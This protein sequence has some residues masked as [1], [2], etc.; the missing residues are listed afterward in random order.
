MLQLADVEA[1]RN[2]VVPRAIALVSAAFEIEALRVREEGLNGI[3]IDGWVATIWAIWRMEGDE[4]TRLVST[5]IRQERMREGKAFVDLGLLWTRASAIVLRR[6]IGITH[7]TQDALEGLSTLEIDQLYDEWESERAGLIAENE[8][9]GSYA[10][11]AHE[12]A[13]IMGASAREWNT[14]GDDRVRESHELVD[15]QIRLIGEPFHVG[16]ALLDY[17]GDPSGP[18]EET[19][20]CR[21]WENFIL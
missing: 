10:W 21:C 5:N 4:A 3:D 13:S 1:A 19:A 11:S 18:L 17:P 7:T 8:V 6:A 16:G 9:L 14:V 15:G 20:N 12:T 2:R